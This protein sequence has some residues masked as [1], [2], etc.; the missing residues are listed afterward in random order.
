VPKP[1]VGRT[2]PTSQEIHAQL[3]RILSSALFVSAHRASR[4]LR[5][6]VEHALGG[7]GERV[8]EVVIG[9]EVFDRGDDFDPSIDPIVRV[10]ATRLR[11]KLHRYARTEGLRD[12]LTISLK[13]GSYVPVARRRKPPARRYTGAPVPVIAVLPFQNL[14]NDPA[15]DVLC[16][17]IAEEAT[18]ALS[19]IG[20]LR[21]IAWTSTR[22]LRGAAY[23]IRFVAE[24]LRVGAVV[25][26]SVR[27]VGDRMRIAIQLVETAECCCLR[28]EVIECSGDNLLAVRDAI[29][30]AVV[31]GLPGSGVA[32]SG[33]R[34]LAPGVENPEHYNLYL[35]GKFHLN[36]RTA[37][38]LEKASE[39]FAKLMAADPQHARGHAG[40]A[41]TLVLQAWYGYRA[42]NVVMPAAK[43]AALRAVRTD[44]RLAAAHLSLGLVLELYDWDWARARQSLLL[45]RDLEPGSATALFEYGLFLS[46]MGEL[47][48]AFVTIRRAQGW[49]PLSP[50][51]NT[52]LGVIYYYQGNLSRAIRQYEEALEMDPGYQPA[53]YRLGLAY[54][55][56]QAAAEAQKHIEKGLRLP[57]FSPRLLGLSGYAMARSGRKDRALAILNALLASPEEQYVSAVSIAILYLGMNQPGE[58]LD[59]LEHA[60]EQHDVLLVD[61]KIDP[62]YD[63]LRARPAFRSLVGRLHLDNGPA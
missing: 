53:Y 14:T 48:E 18:R 7:T 3:A 57:G 62:L 37:E 34:P 44:S 59:W 61:L 55:G 38:G 46:R 20:G 39:Y 27:P 41:E 51:I 11:S 45:A 28:S 43:A 24:Q 13:K 35:K 50:V 16:E 25:E 54:L 23:D 29:V 32:P 40:L 8:R 47:D 30:H 15:A 17:G 4:F 26:G 56:Q 19:Q 6:V 36:R 21:V 63:P 5:F 22:K 2:P 9:R 10:E 12:P 42:P 58:A 1:A 33:V 31:E 60:W 52:N 49:D